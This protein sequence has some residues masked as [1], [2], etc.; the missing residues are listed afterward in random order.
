MN[1][2]GITKIEDLVMVCSNCHSMIHRD[3]KIVSI[4]QLKNILT[5]NK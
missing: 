5:N 4:D 3:K 1:D 2:G